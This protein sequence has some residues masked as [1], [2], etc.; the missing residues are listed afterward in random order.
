VRM[1]LHGASL[2][3]GVLAGMRYV[4]QHNTIIMGLL[5][6]TVLPACL[7]VLVQLSGHGWAGEARAASS[8]P[9]QVLSASSLFS[10]Y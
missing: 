10:S 1:C 2:N 9:M 7:S 4:H 3:I 8:W 5:E 6:M